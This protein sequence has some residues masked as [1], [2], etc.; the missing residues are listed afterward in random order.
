[1]KKVGVYLENDNCADYLPWR[2]I[3][4]QHM[5]LDNFSARSSSVLATSRAWMEIYTNRKSLPNTN[6]C[7]VVTL[8]YAF[9]V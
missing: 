6:A 9:L 5:H 8:L 1:M 2:V 4:T 7:K 3:S